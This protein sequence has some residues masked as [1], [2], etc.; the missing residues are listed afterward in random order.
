MKWLKNL[1]SKKP[2]VWHW[3]CY[4]CDARGEGAHDDVLHETNT[5]VINHMHSVKGWVK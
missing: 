4:N 1:F 3:S 5:H 2:P